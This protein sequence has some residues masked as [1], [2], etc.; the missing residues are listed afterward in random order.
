ML[1]ICRRIA[2]ATIAAIALA[3][4]VM[5]EE[6]PPTMLV[7]D[8]SG[9]MWGRLG[10]DPR[11]KIDIVRELIQPHIDDAKD[12]PIGLTFFGHRRKSNCSDVEVFSEPVTDHAAE[13][14]AILKLNPRG[15]G[16]LVAALRATVDALTA[17]AG[18]NQSTKAN[19]VVI[20]D[21]TDN[22]RQDTCAAANEIAKAHPGIAIHLISMTIDADDT[23]SLSCIASATG[24]TFHDVPDA[25][26][27]TSAL[28][29]VAQLALR[30]P[31][32][33]ATAA[34]E[35]PSAAATPQAPVSTGLQASVALAEDGPP[36]NL[37]VHW[38]ILKSGS[39]DVV[40]ESEGTMIKAKLDPGT[41]DVEVSYAHIKAQRE[42]TIEETG[43]ANIVV[44]LNAA[45]LTVTSK[46]ERSAATSATVIVTIDPA[47]TIE[48]QR[49][50]LSR[51]LSVPE[52]LSPGSYSVTVTDGNVRRSKPV[53]LSAGD[54]TALA[55]ALG[56]GR[57]ELSA[58]LR[59]DGGTIEDVVFSISE[60]DPDSPN[61]RREVAR[62]RAP[63]PSFTVPAGTY[64]AS[65][66]SGDGEVQERIAVSAGD[67]VKRALI[68]P[69][70]TVKVAASICGEPASG[71]EGITYRVT[72]LDGNRGE[73]VRSVMPNLS[74]A[75]LP[76]RYRIAA[77][78]DA[79][80]LKA[81]KE[82]L[83]EADKNTDVV[84]N[85]D[86]GEVA[87]RPGAGTLR[88]VGDTVWEITDTAG[89]PVWRTL[90]AEAKAY[91]AP[92]RYTVRLD[93]RDRTSSAAFEIKS[94]ERKV[95]EVS[96]N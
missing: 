21:G 64:Y 89:K 80:H 88:G 58:G 9:S 52:I 54:D 6:T 30:A 85:F 66:R 84:L 72:A 71:K 13:K 79:H 24:G 12:L 40:S 15:K 43:G 65:A 18:E 35:T 61:G 69:L 73:I 76:G 38:R 41:Y 2:F 87:L 74:L 39:T 57:I 63:S 36:L 94:G 67:I 25:I 42:V 4:P 95:V 11:A 96:L 10:D 78:L 81:A 49:S 29:Q 32:A 7:I 14:E 33:A 37:P 5:A 60:D 16:P 26:G 56:A 46:G 1:E 91:L 48:G 23:A 20:N 51:K 27:L 34:D 17:T 45:R 47:E 31:G 83:I 90:S 86:A 19:I 75:L 92:G 59:Q 62:S 53:K 28:D 55:F 82:V 77:H 3:A 70:V 22:C 50:I 8:G 93:S 68:L 44:P